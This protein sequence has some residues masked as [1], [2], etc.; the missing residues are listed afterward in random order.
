MRTN[1][2]DAISNPVL[3]L[4][5]MVSSLGCWV[6]RP[7]GDYRR[8]SQPTAR[9]APKLRCW[10]LHPRFAAG[11]IARADLDRDTPDRRAH[12]PTPDR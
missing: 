6:L 7:A 9:P 5:V 8:N 12:I 11:I 4:D 3:L 2:R 1:G 10:D